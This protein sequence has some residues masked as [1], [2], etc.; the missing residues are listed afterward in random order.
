MR[1]KMASK[2]K[3]SRAFCGADRITLSPLPRKR[4][5]IPSFRNAVDNEEIVA[6]IPDDDDN[7][8]IP[9]VFNPNPP[10]V[11]GPN[12]VIAWRRTIS[13]GA[14]AVLETAPAAAPAIKCPQ[15]ASAATMTPFPRCL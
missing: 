4:P 2:M 13:N 7:D 15:G 14:V 5:R 12:P 6:N 1:D 10:V 11:V 8:G 3:K 9:M